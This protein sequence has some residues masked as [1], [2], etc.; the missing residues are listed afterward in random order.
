MTFLVGVVVHAGMGSLQ[1]K[2]RIS[3]F[4]KQVSHYSYY[5][6]ALGDCRTKSTESPA[7][8]DLGDG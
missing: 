2:K 8:S 7:L 6:P 3:Q 5:K 4:C 1:E